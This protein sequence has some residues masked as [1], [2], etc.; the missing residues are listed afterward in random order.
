[1]P[2]G[3]NFTANLRAMQTHPQ[4]WSNETQWQPWRWIVNPAAT[5]EQ[6]A[7][8]TFFVP[9]K[10]IFFPWGEGSQICPGRRLSEVEAVAVLACLFKAHRRRI[11]KDSDGESDEATYRRF[12]KCVVDVDLVMLVRLKNADQVTLVCEEA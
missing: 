5:P 1:M 3:V 9:S 2:V 11:K 12:D 10:N 7:Q 6:A 4:Y 8:E